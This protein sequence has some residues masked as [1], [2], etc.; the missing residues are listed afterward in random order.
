M[1]KTIF[2]I[3]LKKR[4]SSFC[5]TFQITDLSGDVS[6]FYILIKIRSLAVYKLF[7]SRIR[8]LNFLETVR[9]LQRFFTLRERER[10][11]ERDKIFSSIKFT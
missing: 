7:S 8:A 4:L 6:K 10:E 1:L 5:K 3:L 9:L 11:R 2:I